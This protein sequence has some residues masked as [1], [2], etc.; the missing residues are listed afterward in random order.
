MI[1]I[2]FFISTVAIKWG[3]PIDWVVSLRST[4]APWADGQKK[5]MTIRQADEVLGKLQHGYRVLTLGSG[6]F[7]ELQTTTSLFVLGSI[8]VCT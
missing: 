4:I 1:W 2:G 5:D 8:Y 3:L 7:A 6:Y